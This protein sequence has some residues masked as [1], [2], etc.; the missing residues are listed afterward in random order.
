MAM[1]YWASPLFTEAQRNFNKHWADALR[2]NGYDVFLPQDLAENDSAY[3]PSPEQIFCLDTAAVMRSDAVVAVIDDETI[4]CGVAAE[5]GIAHAAGIPVVAVYTDIRRNRPEGKMYKNLYVVGLAEVSLGIVHTQTDLIERLQKLNSTRSQPAPSGGRGTDDIDTVVDWLET[6]SVPYWS[7]HNSVIALAKQTD[8]TSIVDFGCGTG[9][10]AAEIMH[11]E[12]SAKYFGFDI[13]R[14][15]IELARSRHGWA[16][17]EHDIGKFVQRVQEEIDSHS[18]IVNFSFVLHDV[19]DLSS[20][21]RLIEALERPTILIQDLTS[22]DLPCVLSWLCQ[23]S[24]RVPDNFRE[25][26]MSFGRLSQNSFDPGHNSC[27]S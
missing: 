27:E 18:C 20:A 7:A 2:E 8:A 26:R 14:Q 11:S 24:G 15:R 17:F 21:R 23:A 1:I 5:M 3:S 12:V 4:D 16:Y 25:R 6:H 13:D 9:R 19:E 22:S 10:L